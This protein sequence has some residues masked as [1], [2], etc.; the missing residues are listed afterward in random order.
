MSMT[1]D[2]YAYEI[3]QSLIENKLVND[4]EAAQISSYLIS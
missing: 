2:A 4:V 3:A 1:K